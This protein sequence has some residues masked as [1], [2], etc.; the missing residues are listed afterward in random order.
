MQ[1]LLLA[2]SIILLTSFYSPTKKANSIY[3]F[4]VEAL[5]GGIID[6]A[7][8]K[9]KKILIVN[10][11]SKCGFTPQYEGLEALYE[12]YK[13]HLVVVGFPANTGD[14]I[15]TTASYVSGSTYKLSI[16]NNT[17]G[18][19]TI[20]PSNVSQSSVA[21]RQSVEWIVEAPSIGNNIT[22]LSEFTDVV[23]TNCSATIGGITKS[24]G[25]FPTEEITMVS[26]GGVIKANVSEISSD[27][28][29]TATWHHQ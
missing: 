23:W 5:D 27:A 26:N 22:P 10:T 25:Q 12:K 17:K 8:F 2:L 13:D 14:S 18:V 29:F 1:K 6:F 4:K 21:K 11:A 3:K 28:G 20:V 15:T 7:R 24:L 16:T 19:S 9:G